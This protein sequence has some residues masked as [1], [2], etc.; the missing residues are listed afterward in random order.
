MPRLR[1]LSGAIVAAIAFSAGAQATDFSKV[2]VFG[3]SLS[4]SGNISLATAPGVQPPL[5]FT[6]NPGETAIEHVADHFGFTLQPS[7]SPG[8]SDY[9]WGGAGVLTNSPGTPAAVPTITAQI[10]GYLAAG[11][12]DPDALYSVWGGANDI[13]YHATA[14]GASA[15]ADQLIAA[16]TA[17]LPPDIAAAVAAQISAQV[18]AGAGVTSLEN[19]DQAQV[20]IATAGHQEAALIGQLQAAGATNIIVFNLPNVGITPSALAQEAGNPGA[21]ASLTGLALIYNGQLNTGLAQLGVGIIPVDTYSLLNEVVANPSAFGFANVTA[22]ACGAGSTSVQ[23]GPEGSG[24]PYTYASGTDQSYLFADGVHPTTAGHVMLGQYVVA[25][26]SAPGQTSLLAEAPL[27]SA[28]A[29][30]R[31]VH[32][33]MLIDNQGSGTRL[34]AAVDYGQQSFDA[35]GNSPGADSNNVNL[36]VGVDAKAGDAFNLGMALGV[37]RNKADV[38]GDAGGYQ[39]NSTLGSAYAVFHRNGGY[40]GAHVGFAQ[41]DYNDVDRS[42]ML[43]AL[44]RT[45]TASTDGSQ[46]LAGLTGGWWLGAGA[47]R[48]GPFAGLEW[49]RIRVNG[50]RESGG[51]SSAMWFGKQERKALVGTLGWRLAGDLEAGPSM[52]HPFAEL[53]WNHDSQAD[54]RS[55]TAGLVNMNGTFALDGYTPDA[56]WASVNLGLGADFTPNVSGWLAYNGR[57]ADSNQE[58]NSLNLGI[59]I[60]F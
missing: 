54:A 25:E 57:F 50:F 51:D 47:L 11:A 38:D 2:V 45:E 55:V 48:T 4:D 40:L 32:D 46:I 17:G 59:K 8:G 44:H 34:F 3:D 33:Q 43:G 26:M 52:L 1:H 14:V 24:L 23:C 56:D 29:H 16:N 21:A 22:P 36:T 53:A 27:A 20:A 18:A 9:A 30:L 49:Q 39:L 6:T 37:S 7:L 60:A 58:L 41:L 42:F 10:T 15:V 12:V 31:T 35:T 28:A 5:R 13:F 19:A